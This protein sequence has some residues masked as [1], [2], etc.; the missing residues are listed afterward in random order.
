[1]SETTG[2]AADPQK[3]RGCRASLAGLACLLVLV[4]MPTVAAPQFEASLDRSTISVGETAVLSMNFSEKSP[5]FQPNV[6]QI[7][8][9][10]FGSMEVSFEDDQVTRT[11]SFKLELVPTR[12]GEFTIPALVAVVDGT[13]LTSRPL[14]LKVVQGRAPPANGE[15]E[16]AFVRIVPSATNIYLGQVTPVEVNCY[17]L[18]NI[19]D[20]HRTQ[21]PQISS[22]SYIVGNMPNNPPGNPTQSRIRQGNSIYTWLD[23]RL[24][25][26]PTRLGTQPL[27]PATWS[28][29]VGLGPRFGFAFLNGERTLTVSS[30]APEVHV[31]P[32]PTNGAPPSF[33]GAIGDFTLAQYEAGPAS[34]GVG[35]PITLKIRIAGNGSFDTVTLPTNEQAWREFK[36]YPATSKFESSDTLQMQGSKYFEE[37]VTPLNAE[38]K[39]LPPFAFSYFNPATGRFATLTHPPVPLSVHAT[40]A[41]PQPTII[42]SGA[43]PP[44]AQQQNQEIVHIKPLAGTVGTLAPPLVRQPLFLTLQTLPPLLWISALI[45]RRQKDKLANSPRL[46]RRREAARLARKCLAELPAHAAANDAEK[47]HATVL[48]LLREQLGERLD[49]PAPAITEAVLDEV[50]GLDGAARNLLRELFHACDQYRYTPEH[51]SQALASLIPKVKTAL[52]ALQKIPGNGEMAVKK[53]LQNV[54]VIMLLLAGAAGAQAQTVADPFLQGNKLYEEGKYSLAAAKYEELLRAGQVSP[55]IYFNAGNAW[56]KAGQI[57]RAIYDYRRAEHLAPRDPDIRANLGIA[58]TQAGASSAALP[59]SRWTRWV[60]RAK[61]NEWAGAA[62]AALALFFVVLTARQLSPGFARSSGGLA[63]LLAAGS[64]WLLICLG[65]SIDQQMLERTSIVIVPEAVVRRGP[66]EESQSA[67]TAHDGAEMMVLGSDGDW[68]QVSD[69]S[70]RIGW[71]QQKD[72]AQMP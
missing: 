45:W 25:V 32:V 71:L 18:D 35:D 15:P 12:A 41:T 43:P 16:Q 44:D 39:V 13:R 21:L 27:G 36:S 64:L 59:G 28:V 20:W 50:K 1:M 23:F 70:R 6:P 26:T 7:D 57:G 3:R 4:V 69:A 49:L 42:A 24:A 11:T 14:K 5:E 58:R 66:L 47:F 46:R 63:G 29:A 55:A 19:V 53:M 65:L 62:S 34:V 31:L 72:V 60:G 38:I 9:I 52:A 68:L 54:G 22:D 40:V 8:G 2:I 10:R 56:F 61:L 30:D 51:S 17:V 33:N 67:F 48:H 37:V